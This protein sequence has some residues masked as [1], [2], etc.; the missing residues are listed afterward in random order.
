MN[1]TKSIE[2]SAEEGSP[3]KKKMP[4]KRRNK[5][6][7]VVQKLN[8]DKECEETTTIGGSFESDR[9]S[10]GGASVEHEIWGCVPSPEAGGPPTASE[11]SGYAELIPTDF[12]HRDRFRFSWP[13]GLTEDDDSPNRFLVMCACLI[14]LIL[15]VQWIKTEG[16]T[17]C[18][19]WYME[20]LDN[21]ELGNSEEMGTL[22]FF[23]LFS[24]ISG[25]LWS[26]L[27]SFLLGLSCLLF[28]WSLTYQDSLRP[29]EFPPS[30][31]SP[32]KFR[33]RSG[34]SFHSSYVMAIINGIAVFALSAWWLCT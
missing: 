24:G 28:S 2:A 13:Y 8:F 7:P 30:P 18:L 27:V 4:R 31:L 16:Y 1:G 12:A 9:I 22:S 29:G 15:V 6:D 26:L 34:H 23:S 3:T 14:V 5:K 25:F 17:L 21:E 10:E 33:K 11:Q 32:K 19:R 20:L